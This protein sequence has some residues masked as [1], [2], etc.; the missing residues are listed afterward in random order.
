MA[1]QDI[2][3]RVLT[4][5]GLIY[6]P[7]GTV[8]RSKGNGLLTSFNP[9]AGKSI[10]YICG[11]SSPELNTYPESMK[12]IRT[13]SELETPL[14]DDTLRANGHE[15]VLLPDGVSEDALCREIADCEI[16]LMCYTPV[17][18]RVIAAAQK[19][20][21]IVKY[22]VGIDA[23]D[24]PAANAR[25]IVVVNI[26][27][28]AEETV[29]EGAFALLMALAKKLPVL[30]TR[31]ATKA[32]AWPEKQWLGVDLA[33]KTIGIV[34]CG[35]IGTSMARMAGAGFRMRVLGCDPYKSREELAVRGI[36][37]YDALKDMLRECDFVSVH[38]VLNAETRHLIGR[39]ALGS[40]KQTA[41]LINSARGALVDETA[42]LEALENNRIAGAGLDV[43][44]TEPLNRT[45]HPLRKLYTME[46]VILFPHLTFYTKEAMERLEREVLERCAEI[47]ENRPVTIKSADLRLQ[48]QGHLNTVSA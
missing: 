45:D 32:W 10:E 46:Q 11:R 36:E 38:A 24:I 33:E 27:E 39:D 29:A 37:K 43:Y 7:V 40:M 26:P 20:K 12:I 14:I 41:V 25:G 6:G 44:S 4:T 18:G 22:G 31:M 23:I 3:T 21:A 42:L 30:H 35:K 34:G 13:D 15:L 19:L 5:T 9:D 47:V 17:T 1:G 48:N 8:S 16:L 2:K 28:Y